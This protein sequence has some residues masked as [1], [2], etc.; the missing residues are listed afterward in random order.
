MEGGRAILRLFSRKGL[1]KDQDRLLGK[2][3]LI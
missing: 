1:W 2:P 3:A